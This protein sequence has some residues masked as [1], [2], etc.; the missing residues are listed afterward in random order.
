MRR[1]EQGLPFRT[2]YRQVAAALDAGEKFPAPSPTK[3][4]A[5]RSSTGGVGNLGLNL[6]RARV[7]RGRTWHARERRR[8][9]RAM[10]KLAGR[11]SDHPT[12]RPSDRRS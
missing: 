10:R 2:A 7:R 5:R 9:D 11:P 6:S 12:V 3:L 4:I 8:F 1:V